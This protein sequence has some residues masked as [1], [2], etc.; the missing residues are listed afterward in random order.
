MTHMQFASGE[1]PS[2]VRD[3]DLI[4]EIS[5]EDAHA[6]V[7]A[8][9]SA[10]A[11]A[12]TMAESYTKLESRLEES[13][14]VMQPQIDTLL[15]E[16]FHQFNPP[17]YCET[18]DEYGGLEYG[19]CAQQ[20]GCTAS[21][22]WTQQGQQ[23]MFSGTKGLQSNAVD[24]QHVVTEEHPSCHLPFI[25]SGMDR[26][27]GTKKANPGSSNNPGNGKD[28][29]PPLCTDSASCSLEGTTV[30]QVIYESG[31]EYDIWRITLGLDSVDTGFYPISASELKSKMKSRQAGW[32][33][34]AVSGAQD[35][36][37][38]DA[39]DSPDAGRCAEINQ[40]AID[41]ALSMVPA[42]TRS[43][44]EKY[45]QKYL[46]STDDSK[47]CAAGPCWIWAGLEYSDKGEAGV[48]IKAPSFAE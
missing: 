7:A 31:S 30:T 37:A 20:P 34:A 12:T 14:M 10:F 41:T 45:G 32:E 28:E 48:T 17:C 6:R 33:A 43:R 35:K 5:Y 27:T 23:I 36:G 2:L 24:S 1:I 26:N 38:F 47:V 42:K 11:K 44:Y 15:M 40:A 22:P 9:F 18:K 29:S 8:D 25:H 3:R 19:T 16:G 39:M 21:C 13:L 4:P 46:V